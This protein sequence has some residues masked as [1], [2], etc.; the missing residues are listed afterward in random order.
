MERT[1]RKACFDRIDL[2]DRFRGSET[3]VFHHQFIG[4]GHDLA[5]HIVRFIGKAN[6]I[7][8]ALRHLLNAIGAFEQRQGEANLWFLVHLLHELTTSKQVEQLVGATQ[9]NIGIDADRIV[10]LHGGIE[11]LVQADRLI[12]VVALREIVTL[13]DACDREIGRDLQQALKVEC[14]QPFRIETQ[15][16]LFGIEDLV[17]LLDIGLCVLLNLL[18]RE[19]RTRNIAT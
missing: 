11:K 8:V 18:A 14:K 12:V 1:I 15:C 9:F 7:T 10:G 19:R 3:I 4:N 16:G 5:E 13:K 17:R 6:V 2:V